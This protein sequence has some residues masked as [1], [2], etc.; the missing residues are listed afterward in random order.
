MD[1]D[2]L[3]DTYIATLGLKRLKGSSAS[4]ILPFFI[5][6]AM[7]SILA[8]DIVPVPVKGPTKKALTDWTHNY[9]LFNRSFFRAFNQDQQDEVI[10]IMDNFTAHIGNDITVTQVSVMNQLC[11]HGIA[12][13]GQKILASAMLCNILAQQ[14]DVI[15]EEVYKRHNR[16]IVAIERNSKIWMQSYFLQHY[17]GRVNPNDDKTI[18]LAVAILCK[19]IVHFLDKI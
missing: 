2:N 15:W 14:A 1:I 7:Y 11:K 5:L 3:V 10:D 19:K 18:C 9:N 6:D 17:P 13:E 12:F 16:Y 8:K 4:P